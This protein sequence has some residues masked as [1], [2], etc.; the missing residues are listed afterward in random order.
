MKKGVITALEDTLWGVMV[1]LCVYLGGYTEA[2]LVFGMRMLYVMLVLIHR[3]ICN[4][5]REDL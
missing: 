3:G 5:K 2:I 1:L 4:N